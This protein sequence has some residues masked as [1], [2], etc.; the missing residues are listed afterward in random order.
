[1][2]STSDLQ[3]RRELEDIQTLSPPN[4]TNANPT[5]PASPP[6]YLKPLPL[7]HSQPV[8]LSQSLGQSQTALSLSQPQIV[9]QNKQLQARSTLF[10]IS[11]NTFSRFQNSNQSQIQEKL[12]KK[13]KKRLKSA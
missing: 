5:Q 1:M 3:D 2:L 4:H 7:S 10:W 6:P 11:F 12:Q 13:R 9:R 8:I